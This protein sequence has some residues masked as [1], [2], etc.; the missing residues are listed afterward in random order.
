MPDS[1]GLGVAEAV[2]ASRPEP[3]SAMTAGTG[4]Q[5]PFDLASERA[6][7]LRRPL[8]DGAL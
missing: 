8:P 6:V 5:V 4:K 2:A 7:G 1:E 3:D